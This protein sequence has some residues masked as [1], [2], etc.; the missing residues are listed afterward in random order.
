MADEPTGSEELGEAIRVR[1][2]EL[3][4]SRRELADASGLSYPYVSQLETGYRLPSQKSLHLLARALHVDPA[5][6]SSAIVFEVEG[7]LMARSPRPRAVRASWR[8][9]PRYAGA[10]KA[11]DESPDE[12]AAQAS[13]LF[14]SLPHGQRLDALARLQQR[15]LEG[16]VEERLGKRRRRAD[17][18][19]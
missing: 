9:N 4:L 17:P 7:D 15:V 19:R 16:L 5:E 18:G 11:E 3:G 1:R 2:H 8:S 12:V 6:L 13:R 14:A 10:A